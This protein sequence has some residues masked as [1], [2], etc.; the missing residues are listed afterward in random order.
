MIIELVVYM[1]F[2]SDMIKVPTVKHVLSPNRVY[3]N[4]LHIL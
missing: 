2:I 4:R 1:I 3:Y